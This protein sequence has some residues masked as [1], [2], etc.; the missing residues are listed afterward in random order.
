MNNPSNNKS[1]KVSVIIP[2]YNVEKYLQQAIESIIHQTLKEIEER[3]NDLVKLKQDEI[4]FDRHIIPKRRD[5]ALVYKFLRDEGFQKEKKITLMKLKA[6]FPE[7]SWLKLLVILETF[8]ECDLLTWR[9]VSVGTYRICQ[10]EAKEKKDLCSAPLM[11]L[12]MQN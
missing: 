11:R 1:I 8:S 12:L 7:M 6:V 5:F 10:L 9:R 4:F 3:E 2:I